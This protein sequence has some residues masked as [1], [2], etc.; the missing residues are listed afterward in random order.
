MLSGFRRVE[1]DALFDTKVA[2]QNA[3]VPG[4]EPTSARRQ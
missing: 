2:R 4:I 3:D 1:E